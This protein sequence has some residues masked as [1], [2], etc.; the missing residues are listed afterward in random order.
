MRVLKGGGLGSRGQSMLGSFVV[1]Q[2]PGDTN[3]EQRI[4]GSL[5]ELA[6]AA[7]HLRLSPEP[8]S[9]A[10]VVGVPREDARHDRTATRPVRPMPGYGIGAVAGRD[11]AVIAWGARNPA[12]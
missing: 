6:Q 9:P 11:A 5:Q 10:P 3:W 8:L 7:R 2:A 1:D 4:D 12:A